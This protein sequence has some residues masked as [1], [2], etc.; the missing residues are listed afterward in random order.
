MF[1]IRDIK[2]KICYGWS[3]KSGCTHI[4]N[5]LNYLIHDVNEL[6]SENNFRDSLWLNQVPLIERDGEKYIDTTYKIIIISR[7]PFER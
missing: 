5:I 2:N 4:K 7:N 3:A 6:T 1:F